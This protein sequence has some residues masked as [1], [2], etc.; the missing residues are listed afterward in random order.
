V[1]DQ[2][3]ERIDKRRLVGFLLALPVY[4]ALLMFLPA[5]TWAWTKGV[6]DPENWTAD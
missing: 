3:R 4:F 5:G 2:P 6:M 1:V